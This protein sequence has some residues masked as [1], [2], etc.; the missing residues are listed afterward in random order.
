MREGDIPG[1]WKTKHLIVLV[2]GNPLPNYVAGR[3]LLEEGG[4]L[5]LIHSAETADIAKRI[6][7]SFGIEGENWHRYQVQ[8]SADGRETERAVK[9]ALANCQTG[10]IGLNYTGGTKAMSAHAYQTLVMASGNHAVFTYLDAKT[11]HLYRSD[12]GGRW[13]VQL[14]VKPTLEIIFKLHD[15]S[16]LPGRIQ[17]EYLHPEFNQ[18]MGEAFG[19][20]GVP[21][22]YGGWCGEY[23]R[24]SRGRLVEKAGKFPVRPIPFP[25]DPQLKSVREALQ[26]LFNTEGDNFDPADVAGSENKPFRRIKDMVRYLDGDW[27]EHLAYGALSKLED[28]CQLNSLMMTID[29]TAP[30]NFE[31][32]VAALR[33]YRFFALSCTRSANKG[34]CKNKLFE[35]YIRA[36]QL[37]GD[38]AR[39]GL[40]CAYQNPQILQKE[41]ERGW[42][43]EEG[44]IR[45][46]G[47]QDMAKLQNQF[48]AWLMQ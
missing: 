35:V 46:F 12:T 34:V 44:Q 2:G 7:E 27:V 25:D 23:L 20:R 29:T 40:V 42:G 1:D 28:V 24:D 36:G 14:L 18:A 22:A 3:L 39:I 26:R 43:A 15:I 48:Y 41:V 38:E 19:E 32:D 4:T 47:V 37:G 8:D 11:L 17:T 5:H 33:G 45:V 30:Y 10:T 21:D 6:G 13:P 9:Q 16:Y 31:F